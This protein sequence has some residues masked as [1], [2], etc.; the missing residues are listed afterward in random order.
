MTQF[1]ELGLAEPVLRALAQEGYDAPTPIQAQSIPSLLQGKDLLGIAQ[2][3][4]G[5]TAAFALPILDRLSKTEGRTPKGAC[6]VLVLA[7]T[8]ELAAQIGDSF[9]AYGRFLNVRVA[10]VVG[11]VAHGPQIKAI[12]PG[13]EVLVA[14]PGRLL[15]H[16]DSGK[17]TL[18]HVDVVVLDEA[19]HMLDLGFLPPIKRIIKMLPRDRQ[20][21]FFSATMPTQI[22]QLAGDMLSDPVKVSVTPVATTQERVDQSVYLIER[23]RKRQLL[24]E[25]LDNPAFK[26]TLVF[27]RTKRGADRVARHLEANK[28]SA[29]AIHGNKSQNQRER[30]LNAFKDGQIGVLV[31]TDIAARGI[32]VD[33]VT[34]VVNFELPN[35]PESYVHRIGRTARGGASGTA[36]AF[37]DEEERGLLRDI[38]KTTRQSIPVIDRRDAEAAAAEE[39]Q[40][41]EARETNRGRRE[42]GGRGQGQGRGQGRGAANGQ[43]RGNG[44]GNGNGGRNA[45]GNARRDGEGSR[46]AAGNRPER[47]S[48][49]PARQ[50]SQRRDG[51]GNA[52]AQAEVN[53]ALEKSRSRYKGGI[54][55]S[56]AN[57]RGNGPAGNA[58][59]SDGRKRPVKR[60]DSDGNRRD[61]AQGDNSISSGLSFMG[62]TEERRAKGNGGNGARNAN[63][64]GK[65]GGA[66]RNRNPRGPQSGGQPGGSGRANSSGKQS[67]R[68]RA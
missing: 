23:T 24:A 26:R 63:P 27:T 16:V 17:L 15:D 34:H 49:R 53:P 44:R 67:R 25:L 18:K 30:A 14:T 45:G 60:V 58:G 68:E 4:T 42:G 59:S 65:R 66:N 3:G 41:A 47:S 22:G 55:S 11:G 13:I 50:S 36:I 37:C 57:G 5:K 48:D 56:P 64:Q 8:R 52:N 31:A 28:I 9:R 7:P 35:V 21:L 10:V 33:G 19:D 54:K 20:N 39:A 38:E 46:A 29:A 2:T 12:T 1:S 61:R 51:E 32:D 40:S 62:S 43:G 6:R